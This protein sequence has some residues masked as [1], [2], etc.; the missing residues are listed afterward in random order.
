MLESSIATRLKQAL[1]SSIENHEIA[2]ANLMVLQDGKEIFYHEDG[3]ADLSDH[4]PIRRDTIFRLYSM[5]KP[6]TATAVMMLI[7]RGQLDLFDPVSLYIPSFK[8][9]KVEKHGQTVAP[10]REVTIQDLLHMTSGLMYGGENQTGQYTEALFQDTNARLR[11]DTPVSTLEFASRLGQ[12]TLAFEP[13][14]SWTYGTS[15]DVLG[16]VVEVVSGQRFGEFLQQE[17]FEPLEMKDTGFWLSE[18]QRSRLAKTVQNDGSGKLKLYSDD[19]LG[20]NHHFDRE[21]AFESGGAGLAS[22]LGDYAKFATMLLQEGRWNGHTLLQSKTIQKMT[23]PSLTPA[24]QQ[25]FDSGYSAIGHSYGNQMR[26]L[27]HS[28]QSGLIGHQGEYGWDGWLGAYFTNSPQ[29]KLT[30]LFMI[31]KRDAGTLP[32]TRKLRNIVF[33]AF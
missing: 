5:S 16:A 1:R 4:T 18:E 33:S 30:F 22:T 9:V 15:A 32:I 2:G 26:I 17:L 29:E 28:G 21:P 19:H 11:S 13:G 7:E 20:I 8:Q 10:M 3:F 6:V 23:A 27:T 14:S 12:G 25:A 24:Q 31:Q